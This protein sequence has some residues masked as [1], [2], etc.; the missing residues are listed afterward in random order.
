MKKLKFYLMCLSVGMGLLLS[1]L[2]IMSVYYK[3][4]DLINQQ[5]IEKHESIMRQS[6]N[7][8]KSDL[9]GMQNILNTTATYTALQFNLEKLIE[10]DMTLSAVEKYNLFRE[11][12]QTLRLL[13][14]QNHFIE[15]I[16]IVSPA[17]QFSAMNNSVS[18]QLNTTNLIQSFDMAQFYTL[19]SFLSKLFFSDMKKSLR[20]YDNLEILKQQPFFATN[21]FNQ[22]NQI[23]GMV[24]VVINIEEIMNQ[25]L[26]PEKYCLLQGNEILYQGSQFNMEDDEIL[27]ADISPFNI[28]LQFNRPIS[29]EISIINYPIVLFVTFMSFVIV[30]ILTS[31]I[32]V[33]MLKPFHMLLL[34]IEKTVEY[35]QKSSSITI[36]DF[37][38]KT[39]FTF[40]E[41]LFSYLIIT[42]LIPVFT[43]SVMYYGQIS[44]GILS[45][46]QQE[47]LE[48]I[49]SKALLI[50][51]ELSYLK[52]LL[53]SLSTT[54][55][56]DNTIK[57][58]QTYDS[59]LV[60]DTI[61]LNILEK[62]SSGLM[63]DYDQ[64]R[65]IRSIEKMSYST[66]YQLDHLIPQ[67]EYR[68]GLIESESGEKV[69]TLALPFD[70]RILENTSEGFYVLSID[71]TFF[72]Q[73]PYLEM[74]ISETISD[75]KQVEW[76]IFDKNTPVHVDHFS[77]ELPSVNLVYSGT[78]TIDSVHTQIVQIFWSSSVSLLWGVLLLFFIAYYCSEYFVKLFYQIIEAPTVS[79]AKKPILKWLQIDE[80]ELLRQQFINQLLELEQVIN[81]KIT[82]ETRAVQIEY[83]KRE[84]QLF[85]IQNQV[86]P[87]FLYNTLENLLFLVEDIQTDRAVNMIESLT[88]F[89]QFIT[90]RTTTWVTLEEEI[91]F[92]KVYSNMMKIRFDNFI[93]L[94]QVEDVPMNSPILKLILQ[95][96]IE[97][98][99]HHGVRH[100]DKFVHI[101]IN[102]KKSLD[103]VILTISDDAVGI[104]ETQLTL[105]RNQ[106]QQSRYNQSGIYNVN[107][108]L[109][110][111][112]K[113][114][115]SLT[116]ESKKGQGTIVTITIPL[117]L[118]K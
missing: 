115:A 13:K 87:H 17:G 5:R 60:L 43:V 86:N 88:Y 76:T 68:L 57:M 91:Q 110:L 78:Y 28:T 42:T 7:T 21:M 12:T 93:V 20:D 6:V 70:S 51:N 37:Y 116:I 111:F 83:E 19:D 84:I 50:D 58:L 114:R 11:I 59:Q 55:S 27:L 46:I 74:L 48:E 2:M 69:L 77:Y 65:Y 23:M 38:G 82:I 94:W 103:N 75:N 113:N 41:R 10:D 118:L 112:Y 22:E 9:E 32:A 63:I 53:A 33:G 106:L 99:I 117:N 72:N 67:S 30:I 25:L 40:R 102:I 81:E 29:H 108:R 71:H 85:A 66:V 8:I 107:D 97:N 90:N 34:W 47:I 15:D 101:V 45:S 73:L 100:T 4:N 95:P 35:N 24:F 105:I 62:N 44:Q 39:R 18:Y 49:Q 14:V 109:K 80:I 64:L 92:S 3:V 89:F 104:E 1:S 36:P 52:K 96:L 61:Q 54:Q 16:M 31:K 56:A 79:S 26:I 98:A